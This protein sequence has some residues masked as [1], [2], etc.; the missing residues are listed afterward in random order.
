MAVTYDEPKVEMIQ[1]SSILAI[2]L[3]GDYARRQRPSQV[4]QQ[5]LTHQISYNIGKMLGCKDC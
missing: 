4:H 2:L 5:K 1:Y 3:C